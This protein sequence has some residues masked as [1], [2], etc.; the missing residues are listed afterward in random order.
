MQDQEYVT[1]E[2]ELSLASQ[3]IEERVAARARV[4]KE[5]EEL[6]RQIEKLPSPEVVKEKEVRQSG[7]IDAE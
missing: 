1:V 3:R 4:Q 7:V 5:I 2:E 6:K